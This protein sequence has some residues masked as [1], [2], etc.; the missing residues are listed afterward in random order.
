MWLTLP[1]KTEYFNAIKSG[2]KVEEYR[3]IT[4]YWKKR[5]V[6][7]E[8]EGIIITLGYPKKTDESRRL[9]FQWRGYQITKLQHRHFGRDTV[10]V[11]ALPL[12]AFSV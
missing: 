9:S 4:D 6:G 11:F 1:V 2:E 10:Y 5:L 3:L 12:V 7:R 8:Y